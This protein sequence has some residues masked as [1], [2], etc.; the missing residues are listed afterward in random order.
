[1][2]RLWLLLPLLAACSAPAPAPAPA[3]DATPDADVPEA[4]GA[5][6]GSDTADDGQGA[7]KLTGLPGIDQAQDL[8]ARII[9]ARGTGKLGG[10]AIPAG[11]NTALPAGE[12]MLTDPGSEYE[13][14]VR[15]TAVPDGIVRLDSGAA[16][17]IEPGHPAPRFRLYAGHASFYLPHIS[18]D[19][20]VVITPAGPLI[21]H[22]AVFSVTVSPDAQVLV[23]CRQGAVFLTGEQNAA[24]VP[25]QVLVADTLGRG[26]VYE[27]SPTEALT[28]TD[29]W[30]K[31]ASEEAPF[32][33]RAALS[34]KLTQWAA[35]DGEQARVLAYWFR[36]ARAVLGDRV[37]GPEVWGDA[38]TAPLPAGDLFA[39]DGTGLLGPLP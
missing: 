15:N 26:R 25:G 4:Q 35:R 24:A 2:K 29:H 8:V 21:T 6:G 16:F 27:M 12:W 19:N 14:T 11:S 38:L 17:I 39:L 18:L 20:V 36:A 3:Q 7:S 13:I 37:P 28:F 32:V 10:T 5:A 1:M 23:T 30:L 34:R 33:F 9:D 31:I 22:G